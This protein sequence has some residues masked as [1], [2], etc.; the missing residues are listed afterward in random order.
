[1]SI[2]VA[3]VPS[4]APLKGK[5]TPEPQSLSGLQYLEPIMTLCSRVVVN[6][7]ITKYNVRRKKKVL[8]RQ[9]ID[10][11]KQQIYRCRS[12]RMQNEFS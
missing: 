5:R 8:K 3:Y 9:H 2:K 10:V 11:Y 4:R 12:L 7:N 1:M 6:Y